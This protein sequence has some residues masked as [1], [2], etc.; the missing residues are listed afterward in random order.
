LGRKVR[1]IVE[2][3]IYDTLTMNVLFSK[4][5]S[6]EVDRGMTAKI[7][8]PITL[9]VSPHRWLQRKI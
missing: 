6:T 5:K 2:S 8:G 3:E 1:A 4:L 9:I 7:E